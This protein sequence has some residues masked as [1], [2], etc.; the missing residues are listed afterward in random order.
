MPS[1]NATTKPIAQNFNAE[2]QDNVK[3]PNQSFHCY[4]CKIKGIICVGNINLILRKNSNISKT[5]RNFAK[6]W[7]NTK[8]PPTEAELNKSFQKFGANQTSV[9]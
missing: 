8:T 4:T 1:L 3:L 7:L 9:N 5:A 2:N 6:V